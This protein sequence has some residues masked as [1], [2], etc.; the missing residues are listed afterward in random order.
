MLGLRGA[1]K[2]QVYLQVLW[3]KY[4]VLEYSDT[5]ILGTR[6]RDHLM[7][8]YTVRADACTVLHAS[9]CNKPC[10]WSSDCS[11]FHMYLQ[12]C[13]HR[14]Y[15]KTSHF[16]PV[17]G[18]L[19]R[20]RVAILSGTCRQDKLMSEITSSWLESR[21]SALQI[22]K[23]TLMKEQDTDGRTSTNTSH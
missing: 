19:Y 1:F 21:E 13:I 20:R 9:C 4:S 8:M 2:V 22:H 23:Q 3:C 18:S 17:S 5:R 15:N 6:K 10:S 12:L 14:W 11:I 16:L 7:C